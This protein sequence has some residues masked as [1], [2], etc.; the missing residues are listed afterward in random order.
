MPAPKKYSFPYTTTPV[1]GMASIECCGPRKCADNDLA[2]PFD[3][4]YSASCTSKGGA[5]EADSVALIVC[6]GSSRACATLL[7]SIDCGYAMYESNGRR[8]SGHGDP[9]K[10]LD[11]KRSTSSVREPAVKFLPSPIHNLV[12]CGRASTRQ[13]KERVG[14]AGLSLS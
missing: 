6:S 9:T 2:M 11:A 12:R 5:D 8:S 13:H 1:W 10:S 7:S 14:V 3:K 4:S